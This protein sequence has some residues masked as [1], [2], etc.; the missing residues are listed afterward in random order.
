ML[1]LAMM[2]PESF[3]RRYIEWLILSVWIELYEHFIEGYFVAGKACAFAGGR[4][5]YIITNGIVVEGLLRELVY[6]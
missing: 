2:L 4:L 6:L 1:L 5:K 3:V